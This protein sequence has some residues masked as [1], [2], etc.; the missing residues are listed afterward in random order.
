MKILNHNRPGC[1]ISLL[2]A[3]IAVAF[4]SRTGYAE[5]ATIISGAEW[6][7][8]N[9]TD[10]QGHGGNII[11]VDSTYYW[12][13][14]NKTNESAANAFFQSVRC[15]SSTDLAHW[16]F[17][18]DALSRQPTGELGP[19]R[20]VERPKVIY[21]GATGRYVM[22]M[23]ID[24]PGYGTGKVGIADSATVSGPYTFRRSIRPVGLQSW[25]LNL[26]QD[27]DGTA[28]LLT[29]AGDDHLHID[30]LSADYLDVVSSVAALQPNYE[31]PAM[32]KVN[33]RY[34]LFGSELTGWN[35]N[36]NKFTT[37]TNLAGPWSKW[38]LFAPA[39]SE[40]YNSQ[41]TLI[42]PVTGSKGTTFLFMGDRWNPSDLGASTYAWF[43][44][45]VT[46]SN[47]WLLGYDNWSIDTA[48]GTWKGK[49]SPPAA[50]K[51]KR[52][53]LAIHKS[54]SSDSEQ[55]GNAASNGNDGDVTTRWCAIDGNAGHWWQV[56]L[57]KVYDLS[58][59]EV[60]WE[61]CGAYQYK[62]EVSNDA[63]TWTLAAD[64]STNTVA[65]A[66][67]DDDFNLS[68]RYVRIMVV[69]L[70]PGMW[71]SAFEIGVF[72]KVSVTAKFGDASL[73]VRH[74]P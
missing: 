74:Y 35:C 29:H 9:G 18:S 14:E 1:F 21:N 56:D 16:T 61:M 13:G 64:K 27:D 50:V 37:A 45:Q 19:G 15:Y 40:T 42:L 34:Y 52:P 30:K 2:V 33:G 58:G 11:K 70:P 38:G 54:A 55:P 24:R 65:K 46:E 10:V 26:F 4:A 59:T 71:A 23:H 5:P 31:A 69:G 60:Y 67:M 22:Y 57:G 68:A 32:F 6:K 8:Q 47:L 17:V 41:T 73:A 7:D 28:Y 51:P 63:S 44:L 12:F 43:P 25:D 3:A 66:V 39:G 49:G 72:P 62:I 48:S 53:S 36:D 20:I